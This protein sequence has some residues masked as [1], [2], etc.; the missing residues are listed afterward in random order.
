MGVLKAVVHGA[1]S[2]EQAIQE[3][4]DFWI[5][6][7]EEKIGVWEQNLAGMGGYWKERTTSVGAKKMR[8]V[9][10]PK[11][12]DRWLKGVQ[13]I[14]PEEWEASIRGK[15]AKLVEGARAS[16]DKYAV[17]VAPVL[18]HIAEGLKRLKATGLT[19]KEAMTFWY[20]W[21]KSYKE[22]KTALKERAVAYAYTR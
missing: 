18:L 7:L 10:T 9:L 21:M 19:G 17:K 22:K 15:G 20:D 1:K 6:G 14:S 3:I 4:V 16:A 2:P 13:A 8:E 11:Y 12:F 5:K